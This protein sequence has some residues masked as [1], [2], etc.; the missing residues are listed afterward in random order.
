M[1]SDLLLSTQRDKQLVF[2]A[3]KN[4]RGTIAFGDCLC[5]RYFISYIK[6]SPRRGTTERECS[7]L[8]TAPHL[9]NETNLQE[10]SSC[11]S[12]FTFQTHAEIASQ[13][14]QLGFLSFV[15]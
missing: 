13:F 4:V 6:K 3:E 11:R 8:R 15:N 1:L 14:S 7:A 2:H 9:A 5:G 10:E 12:H